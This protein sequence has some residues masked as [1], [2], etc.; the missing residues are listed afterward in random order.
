MPTNRR[1]F[2]KQTFG[3]VSVG[4][5]APSLFINTARA[6][7][8]AQQEAFAVDAN[9]RVLVIIEFSGGNDGLNT[10][11]PYADSRYASLRPVMAFKDSELK[12]AAGRSMILSNQLGLHPA[13]SKIK[14]LYDEGKVAIVS[15]VGYPNA[16]GS[17]FESADIWHSAKLT[18]SRSDGW[19]GRY[20]DI[21]LL[22]K[23]GLS[24]IAIEDRLPKTLV[25]A[26][27][28]MSNIPNFDE[29]GL[30]TD[31]QYSE[32]RTNLVN[33][34]LALHQRNF[35]AGSFLNEEMRI[36]FDAVNSALEFRSALDHYSSSVKYPEN[37]SLAEG[38]QMLAQIITTMPE[39]TLLYVQMG[40]FDTHS[41]Q[42]NGGNKAAGQHADLLGDFSEA[43]KAFSDD[44]SEHGLAD[45][46]LLMQWSEFGRRPNE[47][48]SLGTDHG[49]ASNL[50]V[51]GNAVRG[52]LYGSQPSLAVTD[53]DD[54]GNLKFNVDF[55]AVYA[56][57]LDK[58]LRS[59]SRAVLGGQFENVGFL[60]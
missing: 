29:Y 58:W 28:V 23:P 3:A 18:D 11:I 20:A 39:S 5:I 55:R 34:F 8:S 24:A 7:T 47:N 14:G 15:G 60:G 56:T 1:Q 6:N 25:S 40:G 50:F 26:N 41:D 59:E 37:N 42:V 35:P 4:M 10:V 19:L 33:T 44:M 57:I 30:R 45:N 32:N 38:L 17:H 53:L 27:V 13:M 51:I 9:R 21:A 43:V 49:T 16:N 46:V 12:D 36:G 54:A 48:K 2:I 52:G 31:E 22:G